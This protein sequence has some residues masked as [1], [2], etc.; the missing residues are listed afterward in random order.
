MSTPPITSEDDLIAE[1]LR[2]LAAGYP[3]AHGLADDCAFTAP[4][5]GHEFVL[6][7]DAI[8]EGVHFLPDERPADIGWKAL[9][10]NVSDLA[11]KGAEPFGYLMSLAF[12]AAPT[13]EWM[14]GFVQGLAAAQTAFGMHLLGGDTDRRPGPL[15]ITPTVLGVVPAGRGVLRTRAR[16][17]DAVVV[18]GTLGD[19][20]L[21]LRLRLEPS[22]RQGW[23]LTGAAA[24]HLLQRYARPAPRLALRDALRAHASAAMDISDGIAKDLGRLVL[25]SRAGARIEAALLPRSDAL[26]KVAA[27]DPAAAL[28]AMLAGDDY[29]ILAT[30]PQ[31][32]VSVFITAAEQAGVGATAIGSVTAGTGVVMVDADGREM[33]VA[34]TGWDHF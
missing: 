14:S 20:A 34:R 19:S 17:G 24:D 11:A 8:A 13:R 29:E 28:T 4:P 18:S 10:V 31:D 7:T 27:C 30:M 16:P 21:G 9:A 12:P 1:F 22:L 32:Q 26:A 5:P 2:P 15:A 6:K 23:G 25:A 33:P 3:G